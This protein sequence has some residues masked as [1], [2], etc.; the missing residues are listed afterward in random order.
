MGTVI[1]AGG[2][3]PVTV[4]PADIAD[5]GRPRPNRR[6]GRERAGADGHPDQL[7][8]RLAP[9]PP[10]LRANVLWDDAPV[11]NSLRRAIRHP[12]WGCPIGLQ[13]PAERH[14]TGQ[15][16]HLRNDMRCA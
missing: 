5:P 6:R 10:R 4:I 11:L 13:R 16:R 14:S 8:R 9:A 7:R 1:E 2:T 15:A 12:H 3:A